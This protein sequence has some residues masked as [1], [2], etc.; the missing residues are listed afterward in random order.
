MHNEVLNIIKKNSFW[1]TTG[2]AINFAS[3]LE[4][5]FNDNNLPSA[6]VVPINMSPDAASDRPNDFSQRVKHTVS[7]LIAVSAI[8]DATGEQANKAF[9]TAFEVV[10]KDLLGVQLPTA[11]TSCSFEGMD[12]IDTTDGASWF[13]VSFSAEYVWR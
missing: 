13:N 6:F 4:D 9:D 10:K 12:Y 7:V 3:M 5:G 8:D 11:S 1:N 2:G